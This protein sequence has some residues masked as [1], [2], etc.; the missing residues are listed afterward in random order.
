MLTSH[1]HKLLVLAV[2]ALLFTSCKEHK[3]IGEKEIA[4]QPAE[5][6]EL[7]TDILQASLSDLLSE[8]QIAGMPAIKNVVVLKDLY[9]K[10]S[11]LPFWTNNGKWAPV[12]DSLFLLIRDAKYYGLFPSD[13]H[14]GR[15]S[16]LHTLLTSDTASKE[17]K[18]DA[19]LWAETDLLLTAAF[20]Q[21]VK[22]FKIGRI[23]QDSIVLKKDSMMN[24]DFFSQQLQAFRNGSREQFTSSLEPQHSGYKSLRA[25]LK[26]FADTAD[27]THY[28][29]VNPKDSLVLNATLLK[30]LSEEDSAIVVTENVDSASLSKAIKGFQKRKG[31]KQ[32]GKPS[33][34]FINLINETDEHKFFRIAIT[35]D[36]YKLLPEQMPQQ[37][38]WVNIPSY[39]MVVKENDTVKLISKVV[40]GKPHTRTPVI[41]SNITDMITYP[42]WTIPA[43]I[44]K[45]EIL[46]GLQKDPAYTLKKGFSLIDK[47]GN[48]IDPYF[49]DWNLYK[50]GIPYKVVQ[51]SGDDNALG[52]IKFNFSNP[53]SVYLHDTNQRYLFSKKSR[54]LS[55]GCV[56]VQA[57]DSLAYYI[58]RSDSL[59]SAN[60]VPVDSLQSWLAIKKKKVIP[61][62]KRIP[63]FIRYFTCEGINDKVVFHEDVYGEDRR[64]KERFFANKNLSL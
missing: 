26:Q 17:I 59:A 8:E 12:S 4:A 53:Y 13:Y 57:W 40:V 46:P 18:L 16:H 38:I 14:Q 61:V 23:L 10:N 62:R 44:I 33:S 47:D 64:L 42:Q 5:I 55:H 52:V 56:R 45:K 37:Y 19:S 50:T 6:N 2:F 54:A 49:V 51:G 25:A 22:D 30:R 21:M 35:L 58:L 60:A 34:S 29:F 11:Y 24:A 15:L 7:A 9:D 31:W 39:N 43:S 41:T 20:V 32:D 36:R 1:P 3:R 27:F 48:V 28:T 63:L